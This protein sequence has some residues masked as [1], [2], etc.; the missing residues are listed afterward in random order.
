MKRIV[1]LRT[2]TVIMLLVMAV[3]VFGDSRNPFVD[4]VKNIRGSVVNIQVEYETP[5]M[6]ING[7]P[8]QD[9]FFKF[10][11]PQ[12]QRQSPSRK[13]RAMGTGFIFKREGNTVYIITNNHVVE[14]G[15]EE[16]AEITVSLEDKEEYPGEI[17]G[18][19]SD[20]DLAVIKIEI[21][22]DEWV[23]I[24][25]LGESANL[26][27]GQWAIA[28]GN[29]FGEELNRTV[30]VGVISALGRSNFN[31]GSDGGPLYQN[32]IQ[33]D[34]AINRGN[35]GGP[36]VNID[37]DV[38]GVNAAI[39]TPNQG[40]VGIGFAIPVDMVR[41]VANDLMQHGEVVRA[42]LGILPQEITSDL[43]KSLD[44]EDVSGVLIAKVEDDTPA[45]DGKLEQGDVIIKF[46]NRE[47]ADV[48]HFRIIVA[49]SEIGIKLPV[50]IVRKQKHKTMYVTLMKRPADLAESNIS[51]PNADW[52][53]LKV[54]SV[55][56]DAAKQYK[57][58]ESSGVF[59]SAIEK[60][61]P[62]EDSELRVGDVILEIN[63]ETVEDVENFNEIYEK[64]KEDGKD[65]LLFRVKSLNGQYHYVAVNTNR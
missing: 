42:Y 30:T 39:S 7:F 57:I 41:K 16:G 6:T 45:S 48:A 22:S 63:F 29:P 27:V 5:G 43:R 11:F 14:K 40:N 55:N 28:I 52:L 58:D 33:T 34:A 25:P 32:Y 8:N 38:I 64:V 24:A 62:A 2:M 56:S 50:E 36:L 54:E 13:A 4:V 12:P 35:S 20:S 21:E 1:I 26:E 59:I 15:N 44:L 18:L 49:E 65:Q 9:E 31:F 19:D 17:V 60:D 10:F 46:D 3:A 61:S 53:G 47:I 51:T 23:T 37:G